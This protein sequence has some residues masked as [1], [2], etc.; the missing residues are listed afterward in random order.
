[1]FSKTHP[2][3]TQASFGSFDIIWQRNGF[4][5]YSFQA[6]LVSNAYDAHV[7]YCRLPI[8]YSL[9]NE[10]NFMGVVSKYKFRSQ[11]WSNFIPIK[12]HG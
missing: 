4:L 1:M 5:I 12:S 3:F 10:G 11:L 8:T 6:Q 9:K 7:S 2:K